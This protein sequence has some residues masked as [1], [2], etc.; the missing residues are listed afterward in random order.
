MVRKIFFQ[1][2]FTLVIINYD[3][4]NRRRQFEFNLE[5]FKIEQLLAVRTLSF[6]HQLRDYPTSKVELND[7]TMI[8][9]CSSTA[10]YL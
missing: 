3:I 9:L 1:F 7:S 10:L 5:Y 8:Y 6:G 2:Q 4:S